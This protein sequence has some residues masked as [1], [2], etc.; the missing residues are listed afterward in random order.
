M[1]LEVHVRTGP[2]AA[3]IPPR[4]FADSPLPEGRDVRH[5]QHGGVADGVCPECRAPLV[6]RRGIVRHD[7]DDAIVSDAVCGAC[8]EHIG[9]L[10]GWS[11][12]IFGATEDRAVTQ[13]RARVY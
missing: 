11:D 9:A 8:N 6:V 7:G 2:V 13:G 10:V 3:L 4:P 12:S 1:R 5:V